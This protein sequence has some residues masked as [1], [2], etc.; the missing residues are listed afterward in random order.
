VDKLQGPPCQAL[1]IDHIKCAALTC[2]QPLE[3][4]LEKIH[5]FESSLGVW[6]SGKRLKDAARK[7]QWVSRPGKKDGLKRLHQYLNIHI[8]VIN[9]LLLQHGFGKVEYTSRERLAN[10]E[11]LI[12]RIEN[13]ALGLQGVREDIN[14]Q[15]VIV[16]EA[17]SIMQT[18]LRI[19][20]GDIAASIR[21]LAAT[22]TKIWYFIALR[23]SPFSVVSADETPVHQRN[24][25]TA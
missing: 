4:F 5:K 6:K 19:I 11:V 15:M 8:G 12:E 3:D 10:P 22:V 7:V 14:A 1:A 16:A 2:G 25:S 23:T 13:S 18:L 17:R 9:M 21:S 24:S 20:R